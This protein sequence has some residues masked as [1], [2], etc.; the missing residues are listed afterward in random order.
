[1]KEMAEM[2]ADRH[3]NIYYFCSFRHFSGTETTAGVQS[4][5]GASDSDCVPASKISPTEIKEIAETSAD[6]HSNIYYFCTFRHISGTETTAG[7]QSFTGATDS[8]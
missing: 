3:S 2:S 6:R 5:T 1:M 8:D 7:V 4:F